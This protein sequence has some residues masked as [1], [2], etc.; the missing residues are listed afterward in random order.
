MEQNE[1]SEA[2]QLGQAISGMNFAM[3]AAIRALI[4]THPHPQILQQALEEE[5]QQALSHVTASPMADRTLEAMHLLWESL[6]PL[7]LGGGTEQER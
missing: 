6:K 3:S 4:K 7:P 1:P 5:F 2:Q